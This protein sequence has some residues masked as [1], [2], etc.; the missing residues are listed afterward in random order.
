[1]PST[2]S[3]PSR[4]MLIRGGWALGFERQATRLAE[5]TQKHQAIWMI[6]IAFLYAWAVVAQSAR[7]PFWFDE[8]FTEAV[9]GLPKVS[10]FSRAI[11]ADGNPPLTAFLT[12]LAHNA[13]GSGE[14]V[15]RLP[16]ILG[17]GLMCFCLFQFVR[18]RTDAVWAFA[19]MVSPMIT[20]A[21]HWTTEARAY[22]LVLGLGA[23]ALVSWQTALETAGRRRAIALLL[24]VGAIA[25]AICA[26]YYAV[27]IVLALFV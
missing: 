8:I 16:E 12:R 13:F 6:A 10:D 23:L 25:A 5:S 18:R 15:A 2:I 7:S 20:G 22:S 26:H 14:L 24:M 21:F 27:Q 1:M 11:Q 4:S 9:A 3:N 19:A 17:F